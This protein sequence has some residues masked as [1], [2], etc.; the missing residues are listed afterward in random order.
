ME[1]GGGR[2]N[3]F[4]NNIING[5]G[6]IHFDARGGGGLR[7]VVKG[8]MPYVFLDR[9][10]Y[11]TSAVWKEKYPGLVNILQVRAKTTLKNETLKSDNDAP[12]FC[13]RSLL[14][15]RDFIW[16]LSQRLRIARHTA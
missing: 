5:S 12:R 13:L 9:V 3:E 10:P 4:V 8:R 16:I 15:R 7:C 11:N 2:H 14:R 1:L 6:T